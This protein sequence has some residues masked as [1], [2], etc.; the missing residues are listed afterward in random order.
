MTLTANVVS[1]H[2]AAFTLAALVVSGVLQLLIER[3]RQQARRAVVTSVPEG[4]VVVI[5]HDGREGCCTGT[6]LVAQVSR[7]SPVSGS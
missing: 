1:W 7:Q 3:Q 5:E 4:T 2:A 6:G